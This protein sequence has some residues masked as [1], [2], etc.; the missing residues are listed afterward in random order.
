[1]LAKDPGNAWASAKLAKRLAVHDQPR[2]AL[3]ILDAALQR[4][5]QEYNLSLVKADL[6]RGAFGMAPTAERMLSDL[7]SSW[8]DRMGVLERNADFQDF[9]SRPAASAALRRTIL[10]LNH[11]DLSNRRSLASTLADMGD[12]DGALAERRRIVE[13]APWNTSEA[14]AR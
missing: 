11:M 13:L 1:M 14:R 12:M 10:S 8:P 2:R 4:H 7:L 9:M 6:L 3:D 5:P